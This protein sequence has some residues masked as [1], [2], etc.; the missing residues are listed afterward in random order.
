MN[1]GNYRQLSLDQ[2]L[3]TN[4]LKVNEARIYGELLL[5]GIM[6]TKD[7]F[8]F[9][10]SYGPGHKRIKYILAVAT[11]IGCAIRCNE[12]CRV[13]R[14]RRDLS[15]VEVTDQVDLLLDL[16]QRF[17][18]HPNL[19][20]ALV[21]EGESLLN[22]NFPEILEQ[23]AL[24]YDLPIKI[25]STFPNSK[26]SYNNMDGLI[27]FASNYSQLVQLQISLGS[28]NK[29]FRF[30][31]TSY[32]TASFSKIREIGETWLERIS[33]GRKVVLSMSLYEET[34]CDPKDIV[35][36]LH[37]DYFVIRIR[38][39]LRSDITPISRTHLT[40]ERFLNIKKKFE[41]FNYKL[42][43]GRTGDVERDHNLATGQY[44]VK[45]KELI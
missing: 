26:L 2:I 33:N 16:A 44:M 32:P 30:G 40:E 23:L 20:I 34:P 18:L 45:D 38:D 22:C 8:S 1:V 19:K 5:Q 28:T 13:P 25:S 10:T 15:A 3:E 14:Y 39:V 4:S 43:D 21:K 35:D 42:I 36:V 41:A 6:T 7:G 9:V 17:Y 29:E 12:I 27:D 37:P 31:L 11:Q 24:R